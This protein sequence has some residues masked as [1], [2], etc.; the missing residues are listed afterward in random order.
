MAKVIQ[1]KTGQFLVGDCETGDNGAVQITDPFEIIVE[2]VQTAQGIQPQAGMLPYAMMV[3][4]R[5]FN[6]TAEQIQ[7]APSDVDDNC[8]NHWA[9]AT[10]GVVRAAATDVP[11]TTQS[12]LLLQG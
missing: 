8:A 5:V 7:L 12:G 11:G 10:G 1:L 2:P 4:N 6:F 3:K 9:Q